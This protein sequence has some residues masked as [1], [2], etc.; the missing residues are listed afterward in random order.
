MVNRVGMLA[1]PVIAGAL[2][3]LMGSATVLWIDALSFAVS[4][5]LFAIAVPAGKAVP[6]A[7][8]GYLRQI[9]EGLQF[10]RTRPVASLAGDHHCHHQI[11]STRPSSP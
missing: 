3:T 11:F 5:S 9:Q 6:I 8:T 7:A 1:G 10:V 4:A 2:I